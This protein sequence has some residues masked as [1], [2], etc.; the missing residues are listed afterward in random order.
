[1][2]IPALPLLW[3]VVGDTTADG[4]ACRSIQQKLR[5]AFQEPD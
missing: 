5:R 2:R 4:S 3:V 1:V